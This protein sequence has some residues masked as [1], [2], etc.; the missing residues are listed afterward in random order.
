VNILEDHHSTNSCAIDSTSFEVGLWKCIATD[1]MSTTYKYSPLPPDNSIRVLH[2]FPGNK[3]QPWAANYLSSAWTMIHAPN[4]KLC[5]TFGEIRSLLF[6]CHAE[7]NR[8]RYR[9][10]ATRL[11]HT[12]DTHGKLGR[13]GLTLF[14]SINLL[15]LSGVSRLC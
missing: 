7:R 12:C 15:R 2:L 10:I 9:R 11:W 5:P 6:S 4:M 8:S 13:Y 3:D 14:V 1:T